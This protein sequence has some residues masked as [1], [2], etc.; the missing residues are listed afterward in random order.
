MLLSGT[1]RGRAIVLGAGLQGTC[2]ALE[3]R[4]RGFHVDLV[5]QAPGCMT[6]A[7][8][9]NE[10]KIHLGFVYGNDPS[11]RTPRLMLE[12]ALHFGPLMERWLGGIDWHALR[13]RRFTYA[14]MADSLVEPSRLFDGY[15]ALEEDFRTWR[16]GG[17]GTYLGLAH[18][19]LFEVI[20]AGA[21]AGVHAGGKV[22]AAAHTVEAAVDPVALRALI[23]DAVEADDG[24][25]CHFRHRVSSI[26]PTPAGFRVAGDAA[27]GPWTLDGEI[28]VNCCWDGRL[29]LDAELGL[30]PQRPWVHRLKYRL[31]GQLPDELAHLPSLTFVLGPYGDIV[32]TLRRPTYVSW[33]PACMR[34][35]SSQV[36]PPG[37]WEAACAGYARRETTEAIASRALRE[38][39]DVIPGL[40][41]F[42]VTHVDAGVIFSWGSTDINETWSELHLRHEIGLGQRDGYFSIDTG[43]LTTAPLFARALGAA[44]GDR[45]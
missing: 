43:K 13:S 32:V 22:V 27:K 29:A 17:V 9:R 26:E 33:Y 19:H 42:R 3:L 38:F 8:L 34:G 25:A 7:S 45:P 16:A 1:R 24:I 44:V 20:P 40:D 11:R 10:G 41:R 4:R 23:V 39:A 15:S 6:R 5:D 28:V 35:W 14:V 30:A 12:A 21:V 2:A 36:V 18:D 31:L 37:E